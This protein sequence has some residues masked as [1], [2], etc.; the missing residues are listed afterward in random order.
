MPR[1][2]WWG[3]VWSWW[4]CSV[5]GRCVGVVMNTQIRAQSCM[6]EHDDGISFMFVGKDGYTLPQGQMG[7]AC[8]YIWLTSTCEVQET[9]RRYHNMPCFK[10]LSHR[11]PSTWLQLRR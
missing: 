10:L 7:R 11:T 4:E 8:A 9:W 6:R 1:Y 2:A 3:E 5:C